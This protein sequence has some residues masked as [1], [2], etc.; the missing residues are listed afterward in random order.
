MDKSEN[1]NKKSF[2]SNKENQRDMEGCN[3]SKQD[4]NNGRVPCVL[5]DNNI[6]RV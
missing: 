1:D 6:H 5:L 3:E 4:G 2:F